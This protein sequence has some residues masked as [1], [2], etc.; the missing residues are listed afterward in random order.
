[1]TVPLEMEV[2]TARK[3]IEAHWLTIRHM[4]EDAGVVEENIPGEAID[5]NALSD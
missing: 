4:M 3:V 5:S 2:L 1:M